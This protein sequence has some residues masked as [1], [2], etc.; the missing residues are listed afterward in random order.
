MPPHPNGLNCFVIFLEHQFDIIIATALKNATGKP[1]FSS[2][3]IVMTFYFTPRSMYNARLK[4][5]DLAKDSF[6]E[7]LF[8]DFCPFMSKCREPTLNKCGLVFGEHVRARQDPKKVWIPDCFSGKKGRAS[9]PSKL[10]SPR[11]SYHFLTDLLNSINEVIFISHISFQ[12]LHM[13]IILRSSSHNAIT[14]SQNASFHL[15]K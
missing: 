6:C 14:S 11:F 10:L 9:C 1:V 7:V 4:K 3:F 12:N 8:L 15:F 13:F 5:Q 2:K